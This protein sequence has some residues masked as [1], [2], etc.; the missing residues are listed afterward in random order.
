ML[1]SPESSE[2]PLFNK[3]HVYNSLIMRQVMVNNYFSND[4]PTGNQ[5]INLIEIFVTGVRQSS[6]K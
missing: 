1:F 4:K 2:T 5:S 6:S 3:S